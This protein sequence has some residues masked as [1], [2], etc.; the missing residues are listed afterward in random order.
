MHLSAP[1]E[2]CNDEEENVTLEENENKSEGDDSYYNEFNNLFNEPTMTPDRQSILKT[3]I[4][5]SSRKT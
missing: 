3:Y 4:R 5:K 2:A 1:G